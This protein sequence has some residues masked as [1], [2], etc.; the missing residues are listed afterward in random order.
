[1]SQ[2]LD[3]LPANL[4]VPKDDG[5]SSH[6]LGLAVPPV[7]LLSTAGREISL[8]EASQ[9]RRTVVYCYPLTGRPDQKLPADWDAIP[10]ARGCTPQSCSFR[11]HHSELQSLDAQV[12]GLSTQTTAYQQEAAT[13]LH[14]PFALLSDFQL[15]FATALKLP[16]FAVEGRILIKRLTLILHRGTIQKVF[17]PVFPPDKNAAEVVAYL[18]ENS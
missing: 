3:L 16:T 1:M 13:R 2:N 10:G 15:V 6:L 17:Y 7:S 12:F 8:L 18:A 4:P 9:A 5:A 14:L 11:D